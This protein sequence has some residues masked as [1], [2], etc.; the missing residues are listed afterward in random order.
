LFAS[1]SPVYD[2]GMKRRSA[3]KSVFVA[4]A[5]GSLPA[6]ARQS[7]NVAPRPTM[8]DTADGTRIHFREWGAGRPIVFAAPWGLCSDWWDIPVLAFSAQGWRCITFDRRGHARSDDPCRGYDFD[9]LADDIAA[10]LDGLDLQ[11]AVLAGHS[12]GGAEVVR[13]LTRHH[14]RRVA[15]AVLIAPTTPFSLKTDDNPGGRMNRE[16]LEKTLELLKH[17]LP[18]RVAEAAPDFFGVSKNSVPAETLDWW[19]R[20]LLD[21]VSIKVLSELFKVMNETDF[22]TELRTIQTPTLILQGDID[23][24]APLEFTG[25]PTHELIAGSRLLVY[26]NAAHALPYTHTDRML[27]DI[28]AFAGA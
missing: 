4:L 22:R 6:A 21:R 7:R 1:R 14:S 25:H 23:K 17:G 5:S 11:D 20:M 15:H 19:S 2:P 10:V 13:Y 12:L 18:H 3:L 24:S 28:A 16:A 26:E 27:A 8:I 9:T